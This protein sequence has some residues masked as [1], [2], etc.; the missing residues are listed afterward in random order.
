MPDD[1]YGAVDPRAF[2]DLRGF[3]AERTCENCKRLQE[4]LKGLRAKVKHH[5]K[6]EGCGQWVPRLHPAS[7]HPDAAGICW[8]CA[9]PVKEYMDL[10]AKVPTREEAK[11][12]LSLLDRVPY[13]Y[14]KDHPEAIAKLRK[15]AEGG[16]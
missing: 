4:E 12:L 6:C 11:G 2:A 16:E 3:V 13:T 14:L 7:A 5:M 1:K 10:R 8:E 9:V 15:I